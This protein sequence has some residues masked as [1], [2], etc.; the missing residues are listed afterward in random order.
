M[1]SIENCSKIAKFKAKTTSHGHRS[2]VVGEVQRRSRFA[3]IGYNWWW[4]M[5][6]LKPKSNH[7]NGSIQKSQSR[8]KYVKF[9]QMWRFCSLFSSIAIAWCIMNS[10]HKVVRPI[11]NTILQYTELWKNQSLILHHD[12][13]PAPT[14][15]LV[16]EFLA[17]NQTVIMPQPPYSPDLVPA[18]FFLFPKL[19]TPMKAKRR[20]TIEE[21]KEKGKQELLAIPTA[22]KKCFEESVL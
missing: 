18:S 9:G 8:K 7:P 5:G 10:C 4:I 16:R 20:A 11:R 6:V 2:G 22:F 21:I 14:S 19:K 3:Q 13:A 17:K 1:C 15:M 12:N